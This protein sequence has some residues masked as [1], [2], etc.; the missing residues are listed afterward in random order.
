VKVQVHGSLE[1]VPG[2]GRGQ[3]RAPPP[4]EQA[5][6]TGG[7]CAQDYPSHDQENM[8]QLGGGDTADSETW[9]RGQIERIADELNAT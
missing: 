5:H 8:Q 7:T 6:H 3:P 9:L 2:A 1:C 4:G